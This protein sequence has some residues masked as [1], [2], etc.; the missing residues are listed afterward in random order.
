MND[1]SKEER[2]IEFL[3]YIHTED[4]KGKNKDYSQPIINKI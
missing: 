3:Q 4:T 2:L 1:D